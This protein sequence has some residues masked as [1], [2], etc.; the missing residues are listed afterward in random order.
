MTGRPP[1][2]TAYDPI[3][4]TLIVDDGIRPTSTLHPADRLEVIRRLA[5]R[6][7]SDGQ[8]AELLRMYRRSV[9]R[10]RKQH[11]I[12]PGRPRGASSRCLPVRAPTRPRN[13][14]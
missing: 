5:A 11:G 12:P 7:W 14:G 2:Y 4:V 6:E 13:R 3:A 1:D 9:A 10:A 8:I